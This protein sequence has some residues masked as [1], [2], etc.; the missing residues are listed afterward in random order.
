M[1]I[2]SD[3]SSLGSL[4][5]IDYLWLLESIYDTVVIS[6]VVARE[7][8]TA[9]NARIQA[10]LSVSWVKV[11]VP[12]ESAI[13]TI[14]QQGQQFDLGDTHT[15]ALA[16]QINADELLMN[17]R[18][19]RQIAQGLGLSVIGIFGIIIVAK[20]RALIPSVRRVM[21]TLVELAGFRISHRLYQKILK[22]VDEI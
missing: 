5:L 21:D 10:V 7:L 2:V 1:T 15:L 17:E 3:A 13:A 16:L 12:T 14:R 19:G 20:Q 18:R 11:R 4:A 9:K 22:F 8:A 6:E